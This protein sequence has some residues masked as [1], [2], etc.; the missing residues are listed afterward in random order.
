MTTVH[1]YSDLLP[2]VDLDKGCEIINPATEE[3]VGVA[4]VGTVDDVDTAVNKA[5]TA[6]KDFDRLGDAA[7]PFCSRLLTPSRKTR[8]C[9]RSCSPGAG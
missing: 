2:D 3:V 5:R 7:A 8:R 4:P 1:N 9:W 6:Q